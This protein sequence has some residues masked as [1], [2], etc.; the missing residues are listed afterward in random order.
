MCTVTHTNAIKD[1]EM[2]LGTVMHVSVCRTRPVS[3]LDSVGIN[4][5]LSFSDFPLEVQFSGF[6]YT[7]EYLAE[8]TIMMTGEEVD[9][10]NRVS[11]FN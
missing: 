3:G 5:K 8:R 2:D 1:T 7:T 10:L 6:F 4:R 9:I 11:D